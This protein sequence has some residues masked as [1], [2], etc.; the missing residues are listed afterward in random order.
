MASPVGLKKSQFF[1]SDTDRL[2]HAR[3]QVRNAI[4]SS[5]SMR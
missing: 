1:Q 5:G 4:S 2:K 3:V